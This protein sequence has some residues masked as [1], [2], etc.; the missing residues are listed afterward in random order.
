[1]WI[2]RAILAVLA[3]AGFACSSLAGDLPDGFVY[4]KDYVPDIRQ[5]IRYAGRRNFMRQRL[6]GYGARECVLTEDGG[7]GAGQSPECSRSTRLFAGG[8]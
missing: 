6:P 3:S 7:K 5:D 2:K 4:L 1:M 8:V